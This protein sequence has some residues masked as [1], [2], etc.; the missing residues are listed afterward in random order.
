MEELKNIKTTKEKTVKEVKLKLEGVKLSFPSFLE[1]ERFQ[2]K[3]T[4]KYGATFIVDKSDV[5]NTQKIEEAI[6]NILTQA[7][8]TNFQQEGRTFRRDGEATKYSQYKSSV[9]VRG[10]NRDRP[11]LINRDLTQIEVRDIDD[12]F[13]SGSIVNAVL[14]CW[15]QDNNY[16][17]RINA[18]LYAVQFV[19]HSPNF[20]RNSQGVDGMFSKLSS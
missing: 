16:G 4:H 2:G 1:T 13:Y 7:N 14:G 6:N 5:E 12:F 17:K 18:K 19:E 3:S 8:D 20:D 10:T 9:L 11:K 15:W